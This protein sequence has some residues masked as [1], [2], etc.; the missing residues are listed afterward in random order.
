ML[1]RHWLLGARVQ[2]RLW[3][4]ASHRRSASPPRTS[5]QSARLSLGVH[6]L[7]PLRGRNIGG[8][9]CLLLLAP[10]RQLLLEVLARLPILLVPI[11]EGLVALLLGLLARLQI[12]LV[13]IR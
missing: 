13:P 5:L 11:R 6:V 8:L 4:L 3:F 7:H 9:L 12:L 2:S 10:L 1:R